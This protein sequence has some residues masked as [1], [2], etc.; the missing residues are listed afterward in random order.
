[1]LKSIAEMTARHNLY[2]RGIAD[3]AAAA[4]WRIDGQGMVFP[5]YDFDCNT[6]AW[7]WKRFAG[8][9]AKYIWKSSK[10]NAKYY[11]GAYPEQFKQSIADND[12]V[13]YIAN[14]EPSVL[15]FNA[16]GL[17][18]VFSWFGEGS[19][20][21][22]L[23]DDLAAWGVTEVRYPADN[24]DTGRDSAA[25]VRDK[26]ADTGIA[27]HPL[28]WGAVDDR[29]DANDLWIACGFDSA[30]FRARL[31]DLTALV[32]P[33][34]QRQPETVIDWSS[35]DTPDDLI[36][37]VRAALGYS[38]SE[39]VNSAGLTK[40]RVANPID[41]HEHDDR[42]PASVFNMQTGV[43]IDHKGRNIGPFELADHFGID[44]SAYRQ[45]RR[46]RVEQATETALAD[47]LQD[48][49]A[50][51]DALPDV[52][53]ES[54][55]HTY[56]QPKTPE[57]DDDLAWSDGLLW[58][59]LWGIQGCYQKNTAA[60]VWTMVD[61]GLY[62][63]ATASQVHAA[64]A[65]RGLDISLRAIWRWLESDHAGELVSF[66]TVVSSSITTEKNDTKS[67][68]NRPERH[69]RLKSRPEVRPAIKRRALVRLAE[70]AAQDGK[71]VMP[72]DWQPEFA[73]T[74]AG[75]DTGNV[76]AVTT[77]LQVATEQAAR[78][79]TDFQADLNRFRGRFRRMYDALVADLDNSDLLDD[80]QIEPDIMGQGSAHNVLAGQILDYDFDLEP[81]KERPYWRDC[82]LTGLSGP[83]MRAV[84]HDLA[85]LR[86]TGPTRETVTITAQEPAAA[87]RE[88]KAQ[89]Q[90]LHGRPLYVYAA[91]DKP[92]P[93]K[94]ENLERVIARA[95]RHDNLIY[96]D[97][98]VSRP[99]E[100]FE[101]EPATEAPDTAKSAP[102]QPTERDKP[103]APRKPKYEGLSIDPDIAA[104]ALDRLMAVFGWYRDDD[105]WSD[106]QGNYYPDHVPT[107]LQ[108][109]TGQPIAS[110]DE[111]MLNMHH[112]ARKYDDDPPAIERAESAEKLANVSISVPATDEN[113]SK[114]DRKANIWADRPGM[115][116]LTRPTIFSDRASC[117]RWARRK[118]IA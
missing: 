107:L 22:T 45:Q 56:T 60:I 71:Q 110:E 52:A 94:T 57:N 104:A 12:G 101:P 92:V 79:D 59:E 26:L 63:G 99:M 5:V 51:W 111:I 73:I 17:F 80:F 11:F 44:T 68:A 112:T 97:F 66:F 58:G 25:A 67:V 113:L 117:Q 116:A 84:R 65:D 118:G 103:S 27:F 1:M 62:D 16:A 83:T 24:D 96:V 70:Q 48:A 10:G 2:Q 50:V 31:A 41:R 29:Y 34:E 77:A 18:N 100:R 36:S 23:A 108:A 38:A 82:I 30:I 64:M 13:V 106:A 85:K 81:D 37:A 61:A 86:Y 76:D 3:I 40:R 19:I 78:R 105:G 115:E 102:E 69:F 95:A 28:A 90:Q 114:L 89:A 75:V 54:E 39:P 14:G 72:L 109:L 8:Q 87:Y 93:C 98:S 43:L 4:G 74:L 91:G 47:T 7:R 33:R 35:D 88:I 42:K 20:P 6:S 9:G 46:Q 21:A 32:L 53:I 49:R 55:T 15:A